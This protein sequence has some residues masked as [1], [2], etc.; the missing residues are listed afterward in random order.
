MNSKLLGLSAALLALS[1]EGATYD[2]A[3]LN[4]MLDELGN[5]PLPKVSKNLSMATCYEM[6]PLQNEYQ[7]FI[8][9][10]CGA[11]T[12]YVGDFPLSR[13]EALRHELPKLK[14]LGLEIGIN[15]TDY[16]ASCSTLPK[17]KFPTKARV[18]S[19]GEVVEIRSAPVEGHEYSENV[20]EVCSYL[21]QDAWICAEALD[22][23]NLVVREWAKVY[24][25]PS[26]MTSYLTRLAE[27][28]SVELLSPPMGKAP[29]DWRYIRYKLEHILRLPPEELELCEMS[30]VVPETACPKLMWVYHG[31]RTEVKKND[32]AILKAFLK[33]KSVVNISISGDEECDIALKHCLPRLR[34][35]LGD[36]TEGEIDLSGLF[37]EETEDET[38]DEFSPRT[39][40]E[41]DEMAERMRLLQ[42]DL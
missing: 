41:A 32:I 17:V 2:R 40:E 38:F 28:T 34:V 37:S 14:N 10:K 31:K 12:L 26:R 8:C 24:K 1:A 36:A 23:K 21:N 11:R 30:E 5:S 13:L 4:A 27:G 7:T 19:T 39:R 22:E 16:C 35:L 25:T 6:A 18:E 15:E 3:Q 20:Y 9:P 33:K 29:E 42:W